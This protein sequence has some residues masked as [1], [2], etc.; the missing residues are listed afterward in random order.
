[1]RGAFVVVVVFLSMFGFSAVT[2]ATV[3]PP[4]PPYI[5][6]AVGMDNQDGYVQNFPNTSGQFHGHLGASHQLAQDIIPPFTHEG[7]VYSQN[8]VEPYISIWNAGCV[9]P[10]TPTPTPTDTCEPVCG[11]TATPPP[12]ETATDVPTE[13]M[14]STPTTVVTDIPGETPTPTEIVTTTPTTEPTP[15]EDTPEVFQLPDTGTGSDESQTDYGLLAFLAVG[16]LSLG[17]LLRG[18]MSGR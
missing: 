5:C 9:T 18:R 8:W 6:H 13:T 4:L 15:T 1:M 2:S 17:A 16:L 3:D 10:T 12:T 11:V 7:T 14:T